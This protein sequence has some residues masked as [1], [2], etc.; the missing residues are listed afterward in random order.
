MYLDGTNLQGQWNIVKYSWSAKAKQSRWYAKP[1][2]A[3]CSA[4][5]FGQ[6]TWG[7]DGNKMK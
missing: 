7:M 2:D 3:T 5:R 1:P 4:A 6:V